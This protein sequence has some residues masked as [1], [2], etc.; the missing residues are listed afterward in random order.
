MLCSI[1][2]VLQSRLSGYIQDNDIHLSAAKLAEF[3][4]NSALTL[5]IFWLSAKKNSSMC[6]YYLARWHG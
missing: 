2:S 5:F 3:S 1:I 4:L 6:T